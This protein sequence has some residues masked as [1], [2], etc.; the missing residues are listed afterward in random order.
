MR[1]AK[2]DQ[3]FIP[4]KAKYG[5]NSF[6]E[7]EFFNDFLRLEKLKEFLNKKLQEASEKFDD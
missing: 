4:I 1:K 2:P 3:A 6:L 7:R 5:F